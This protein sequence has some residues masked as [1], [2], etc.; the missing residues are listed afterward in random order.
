MPTIPGT[1]APPGHPPPLTP[2]MMAI[3]RAAADK[4][5]FDYVI[6]VLTSTLST[7]SKKPNPYYLVCEH[8]PMTKTAHFDMLDEFV[9]GGEI[10]MLDPNDDSKW[11]Q[12]SSGNVLTF[13]LTK[14]EIKRLLALSMYW[15]NVIYLTHG[16][17][18]SV[19]EWHNL[20]EFSLGATIRNINAS[21]IRPAPHPPPPR[22]L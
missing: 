18:P 7:S 6:N 5:A 15:D 10:P 14:I 3:T 22:L 17:R 13:L 8:I 1:P 16:G 2:S 9:L 19:A 12:D 21:K 11:Q 4:L 20:D